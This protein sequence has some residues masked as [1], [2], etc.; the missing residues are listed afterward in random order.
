VYNEFLLYLC[1]I[2]DHVNRKLADTVRQSLFFLLNFESA[3]NFLMDDLGAK[4]SRDR[5]FCFDKIIVH[6]IIFDDTSDVTL[7]CTVPYYGEIYTANFGLTFDQ[8][9][10]LLRSIKPGGS[11]VA[12]ILAE[13]LNGADGEMEVPSVVEVEALY[14]HALEISNCILYTSLYDLT[15]DEGDENDGEESD[16]DDET[17]EEGEYEAY[18]FLID[19]IVVKGNGK[20][21]VN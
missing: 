6:E 9:N 13:K 4:F 16:G 12:T 14:G 7:Y 11:E 3:V 1:V 21:S 19:N 8:L 15:D 18:A 20:A 17:A 5:T 2:N 10:T